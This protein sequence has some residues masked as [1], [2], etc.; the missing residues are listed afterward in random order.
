MTDRH[1]QNAY[2]E[3]LKRD[4]DQEDLRRID[5]TSWMSEGPYRKGWRPV[6]SKV[7]NEENSLSVSPHLNTQ[8][9][10]L[11]WPKEQPEEEALKEV[12][13]SSLAETSDETVRDTSAPSSEHTS[14]QAIEP[15]RGESS[16][17]NR[18]SSISSSMGSI[19]RDEEYAVIR[20]QNE[21]KAEMEITA[22]AVQSS[23]TGV[24]NDLEDK[25]SQAFRAINSAH[26]QCRIQQQIIRIERTTSF[27]ALH[28][29]G[30]QAHSNFTTV[31]RRQ[32]FPSGDNDKWHASYLNRGDV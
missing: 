19:P 15:F 24:M 26:E 30:E 13:C 16:G 4:L 32:S 22:V 8:L 12:S 21:L 14:E 23:M 11:T 31:R 29:Y 18:H 3:Y 28:I 20:K 25:T 27:G 7:W 1:T 6:P 10:S 17:F 2:E 5:R 9:S